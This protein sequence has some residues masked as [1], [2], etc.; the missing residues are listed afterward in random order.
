MKMPTLLP[1]SR[2]SKWTLFALALIGAS[3]FSL[4]KF[5]I[6]NASASID[7]GLYFVVPGSH[8]RRGHIAAYLPP[9]MLA[10]WMAKR[11]YLPKG[12]P[13]LKTVASKTGNI[14]CRSG[15]IVSYR[16]KPVA[17]ARDHDRM[18]RD[19]PVWQGCR[20]IGKEEVFLLS[21][22]KSSLDSRYFGPLPAS[23]LLGR[24]YPIW[25]Y[26]SE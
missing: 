21:P 12:L 15:S 10:A 16:A 3:S 8:V 11:G 24:A 18:G 6:W 7:K 1:L 9:P 19:L 26:E 5:V 13:L 25:T 23:G 20:I 14:F 17:V 22:F 4:P 2:T